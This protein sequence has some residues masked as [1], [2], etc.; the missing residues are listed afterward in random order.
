MWY[1]GISDSQQLRALQHSMALVA[2]LVCKAAGRRN[3]IAIIH[4]FDRT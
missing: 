3:V 4:V 2:G 1:Q